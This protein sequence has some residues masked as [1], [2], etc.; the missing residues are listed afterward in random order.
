[1]SIIVAARDPLI[2]PREKQRRAQTCSRRKSFEMPNPFVDLG[3]RVT[4]E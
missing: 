4:L 1:M 3:L 2:F